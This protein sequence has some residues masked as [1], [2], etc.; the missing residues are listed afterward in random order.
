MTVKFKPFLEI[1]ELDIKMIRL[2]RLKMQRNAELS[3]IESL[4]SELQ[5]QLN[6][7]Q[8]EIASLKK[9]TSQI[10]VKIEELSET[11]KKL[12][13]QQSSVKKVE[14]FNALTQ[15]MSSIEREKLAL[16]NQASNLLDNKASEE[17]ILE[18]I[19]ESLN[20]SE[21][22]SAELEK[23]INSSVDLINAEGRQLKS[24]KESL[25]KGLDE[26]F[27]QIY[28]RL[29]RN[30]KDR[31]IVPVENRTCSGC[32]ITLTIQH[33]NLVRKGESVTFCEHCSRILYWEDNDNS[34]DE[35]KP[36]RRR[37]KATV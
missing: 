35:K 15:Q 32:H 16:E 26:E 2:M 33:E 23:E 14:E 31:V 8:E 30:K 19:K 7:K 5:E 36:K 18:K 22:S 3:Q 24:K 10:D 25:V 6:L 11:Y 34:A 4:R 1:Q 12:E 17:E 13:A 20:S 27:M 29:L 9:E 37:R 28:N 21:I